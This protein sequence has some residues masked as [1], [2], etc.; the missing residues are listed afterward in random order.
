[1]GSAS[2]PRC[3]LLAPFQRQV[4][5]L[6]GRQIATACALPELYYL[7]TIGPTRAS[8]LSLLSP[9]SDISLKITA[10][11]ASPRWVP[12]YRRRLEGQ[13]ITQ[14]VFWHFSFI[15][16]RSLVSRG[17]RTGQWSFM[18]CFLIMINFAKT[19]AFFILP[20]YVSF[21]FV[22]NLFLFISYQLSCRCDAIVNFICVISVFLSLL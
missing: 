11:S 20:N 13:T 5:F 4:Q 22:Q 18:D 9:I 14:E 19:F 3:R 10:K 1:M 16:A 2:L 21:S 7:A 6:G 17:I 8:L 15:N 12:M